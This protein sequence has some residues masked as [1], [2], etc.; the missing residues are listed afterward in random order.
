GDMGEVGGTAH[1]VVEAAAASIAAVAVDPGP[2]QGLIG[3]EL[4]VAE[5]ES[6][7]D[8]IDRPTPGAAAEE[9]EERIVGIDVAGA[10]DRSVAVEPAVVDRGQ[11]R[12]VH[13]GEGRSGGE[14]ATQCLA[15][16]HAGPTRPALRFVVRERAV[17]DGEGGAGVGDG[18]AEGITRGL[19]V[20]GDI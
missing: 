7:H 9:A 11:R 19:R 6:P 10:A 20:G 3:D 12:K 1:L 14:G 13:A 2:T 8:A 5:V 16:A 15:A 17:A 4:A 18:A